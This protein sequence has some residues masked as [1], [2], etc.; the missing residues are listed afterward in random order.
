MINPY[1]LWLIKLLCIYST[2]QGSTSCSSSEIP[3]IEMLLNLH[4]SNKN[5]SP[6]KHA[7]LDGKKELFKNVVK[8][9]FTVS[10][11]SN[12]LKITQSEFSGF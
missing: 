10:N 2:A 5:M 6:F 11:T 9:F 3:P 8:Y 1:L 7:S 4:P 12:S